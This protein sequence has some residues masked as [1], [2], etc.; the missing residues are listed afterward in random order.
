MIFE[1]MSVDA[2]EIAKEMIALCIQNG[3]KMG[4]L[5]GFDAGGTK[6]FFRIELEEFIS[7]CDVE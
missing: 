1:D 6:E 5:K 7:T 2:R 3:V 4:G